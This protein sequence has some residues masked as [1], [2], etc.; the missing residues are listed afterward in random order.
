ML[1]LE[2]LIVTLAIILGYLIGS[3]PTAYI[4][5]RIIKGKDIREIDVGNVGAAAAIRQT[6]R[7][8]GLIV[9]F[10]DIA[11]GS[12]AILISGA[13][14]LAEIWVL[15]AGFAA[16]LGHCYPIYIG[17]R[18][19]QGAATVIGMFL[20]LT[21]YITL[22]IL[23][24]LL[25]ALAITRRIFPSICIISISLPLLIYFMNG[26][27]LLLIFSLLIM[28]FMISRNYKG[29]FKEICK[30]HN[31]IKTKRSKSSADNNS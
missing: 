4:V 27:L 15:C 13:M 12:A 5:V 20:V 25:I 14:G 3:I 24:L 7:I 1:T 23:G 21:P 10:I 28:V 30:L 2:V 31:Y 8:P 22:I 29:I 17:F 9:A 11:K 26:S 16:L 19:G 6:G 18:G